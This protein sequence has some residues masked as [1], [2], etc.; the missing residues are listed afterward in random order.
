MVFQELKTVTSELEFN[1]D[2]K[3]HGTTVWMVSKSPYPEV[4]FILYTDGEQGHDTNTEK[5]LFLFENGVD[6]MLKGQEA[7]DLFFGF[8]GGYYPDRAFGPVQLGENI[9]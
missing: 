5:M 7:K 2:I 9:A 8:T 3:F 1:L 6:V 4:Q